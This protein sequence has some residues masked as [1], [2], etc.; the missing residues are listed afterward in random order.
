MQESTSSRP[1]VSSSSISF[2]PSAKGHQKGKKHNHVGGLTA[3]NPNPTEQVHS[4]N[5]QAKL[6]VKEGNKRKEE[7]KKRG[8][9]GGMMTVIAVATFSAQCRHGCSPMHASLAELAAGGILVMGKAGR[10]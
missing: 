6:M 7:R 9:W 2:C 1:V 5:Y 10:G 4:H 8:E 3:A